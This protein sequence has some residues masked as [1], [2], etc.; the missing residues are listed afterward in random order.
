MQMQHL[1]K[2][3][4]EKNAS[5][6]FI[7]AGA[8][9]NIKIGG[10]ALPI[11]QQV[12]DSQT[13][14]DLL[15]EI[16]STAQQA[17][18][19]LKKELNL[20]LPV[21]GIGSFRLSA[22]Q[23]RGSSAAVI[24]FIPHHIPTFDSLGVPEILAKLVMEKRGLI[25][26]VGA[27]GSGKSTTLASLIEL[28]NQKCTGHILTFEDPIEYLYRSKKSV[29][30]QR[31]VGFDT[32]SLEIALKNGMRQAPDVILIGEIRDK[33]TMTAAL[34]YAQ[35]G[36]LVL[37]TMH[38]NNSYH[39][40]NRIMSFYPLENRNAILSDLSSSLR[41]T[42]S[43][44]L[45]KS[46]KGSLRP[47]CEVMLNTR[48]IAELIEK[49]EINQIKEALEKSLTTGS[50]TFEQSLYQLIRNGT[51]SKEDGL[52]HAD[53]PTNLMWLL[54]NT[55]HNGVLQ[56]ATKTQSMKKTIVNETGPSFTEF[57]FDM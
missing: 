37:S 33:T 14:S 6:L 32:E 24:R 4:A 21:A 7:S 29:I 22:Y 41:C 17:E 3:M 25:L 57:S 36:H 55:E 53:S 45:I 47:A 10:V 30:D 19:Q 54:D 39:A 52:A 27:T 51:I 1:F 12:L 43:Q 50:V 40:M 13:V 44:R 34:Q 48:Y 8:P 2:L 20:A 16:L 31:E 35:S 28:R 5:D 9:I 56:S 49:G 42:I 15:N 18:F 26:V 23:Q 46:I 38:A 11:N